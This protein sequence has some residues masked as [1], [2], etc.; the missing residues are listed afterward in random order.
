MT[1]FQQAPV[2]HVFPLILVVQIIV[3]VGLAP[4]LAGRAGDGGLLDIARLAASLGVVIAGAASRI[5]TSAAG[6]ALANGSRG[7]EA[8]ERRY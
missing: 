1:A 2:T 8:E 3:A 7:V 4:L 5:G 6:A